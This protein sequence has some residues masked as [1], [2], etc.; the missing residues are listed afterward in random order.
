[1]ASTGAVKQAQ[2]NLALSGGEYLISDQRG[3]TNQLASARWEFVQ[4]LQRKLPAFGEQLRKDV[5]PKFARLAR[6]KPDYWETAWKFSTWQLHSDRQNQLTPFLMAWARAFQL[7]AESWILEG[8]LETMRRWQKHSDWR[9]SLDI[10]GF[11]AS[12]CGPILIGDAEHRFTFE[13]WGWDPQLLTWRAYHAHLQKKFKTELRAYEMRIRGLAR[14][15]A[16]Q[17]V[18][19]RYSIEHFEWLALYHCGN[20]SLE[21]ILR[22]SPNAADKTT[23]SKGLHTAARL[24][25][26]K[27]RP[28]NKLKKI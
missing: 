16:A 26:L 24:I 3:N 18:T 23:I 20:W 13:D 17:P 2:H 4:T 6:N 25:G 21:K 14:S 19:S 28:K 7:S 27:V 1:M 12:V 22:V 9:A 15:R 10:H 8:A 11:R 5:Y